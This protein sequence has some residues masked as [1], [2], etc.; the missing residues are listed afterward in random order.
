MKPYPPLGLLYI[1]AYLR[2]IG[3]SVDLFDTT[4]ARREA[5]AEKLHARQRCCRYLPNLMT[6]QSVLGVL[7]LAKDNGYTVVLGGPESAN[8][9]DE[10]LRRGADVVVIGEG[11]VTLGELLSVLAQRGP[12]R[13]HGL[14]GTVFRDE[15]DQDCN[16]DPERAQIDD[17]NSLPW[18]AREQ[19]RSAAIHRRVA[20]LSRHGQR[21]PDHGARLSLQMP[22]VFTCGFW[23]HASTPQLSG[24]RR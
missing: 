7:R 4:F 14:P 5:L 23:F 24:L 1:S 21:Q 20:Q 10:Y 16:P 15:F 12:H 3:F 11:E 22:V 18:P 8:Y 2:R 9:P 6:R 17:I 13:L 19:N